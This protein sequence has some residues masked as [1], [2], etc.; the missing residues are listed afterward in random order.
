MNIT[1][2]RVSA[3]AAVAAAALCVASAVSAAAVPAPKLAPGVK[4]QAAYEAV[5]RRYEVANPTPIFVDLAPLGM[6]NGSLDKV[7]EPV[8]AIA[9]VQGWDWL[10]IGKDGTGVGYVPISMLRPAGSR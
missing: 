2:V 5:P 7:G 3:V 1:L 8:N 9:K 6:T 10:L 4:A